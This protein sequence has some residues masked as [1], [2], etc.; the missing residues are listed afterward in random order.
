M[1]NDE[2]GKKGKVNKGIEGIRESVLKKIVA[3]FFFPGN[4]YSCQNFPA[5]FEESDGGGGE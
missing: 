2:K 5:A 3:V 1:R 4:W